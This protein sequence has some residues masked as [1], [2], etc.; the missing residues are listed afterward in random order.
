[1]LK[2]ATIN[3]PSR[4]QQSTSLQS[5]HI[6]PLGDLLDH[7]NQISQHDE[8]DSGH[9]SL[10]HQRTQS[11]LY[12]VTSQ[13]ISPARR[14]LDFGLSA[15]ICQPEVFTHGSSGQKLPMLQRNPLQCNSLTLSRQS[16][17]SD[18]HAPANSINSSQH[19]SPTS[20]ASARYP[21]MNID[22]QDSISILSS[23]A[24]L[25]STPTKATQGE[26][27]IKIF[28]QS[29]S[30]DVEYLTLQ[31]TSQT[32]SSQ[33]IRS[34]LRK[35]RLKHRDP[36]LFYLT[37]ERWIRI[38][39]IKSKN[40]MLLSDD[41]CPLQLQ[42]CCSNPPHDDIKFTLQMRA[43]A[44]VKIYCS[45]VVKD[46]R[47][48][49]LS[50]STQTT[51]EETIELMLHCLNL[52]GTSCQSTMDNMRL[53]LTGSPESTNS[54]NSSSSGVESDPNC[55]TIGNGCNIAMNTI[56]TSNHLD[57]NSRASSVTSISTSSNISSTL[58][59]SLV[60]QYC[61][62]IE[63]R[64]TNYR[65]ILES[66]EYL[67]DV[68]QNLLSE[69]KGQAVDLCQTPDSPIAIGNNN[70]S[71]SLNSSTQSTTDQWFLIK[72]LKRDDYISRQQC[73][74][75]AI[76]LNN[77]R[78]SP[79]RV[80]MMPTIPLSLINQYN[81]DTNDLK[82][83]VSTTQIEVMN[84]RSKGCSNNSSNINV[85]NSTNDGAISAKTEPADQASILP[86]KFILL[87]PVKPRRR[88]LSNASSTFGPPIMT[89][90]V[91]SH[92]RDSRRRYDPARLAEDL[93]R[94]DIAS[95]EIAE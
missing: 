38:D 46:A 29:L 34:L 93:N 37:L 72:L 51:V 86:P 6:A 82:H 63:C 26:T 7:R 62:L 18:Y 28:A 2:H 49:C 60:E 39:G 81:S 87:P 59:S 55:Q 44:L 15:P 57:S 31:V 30:Q 23:S 12:P 20:R 52:N 50:L 47:Y 75:T 78:N 69:A 54:S 11:S 5:K 91:C 21:K 45:D 10:C 66:D 67:V 85:N 32:K 71:V 1:M 40:V 14:R 48:K 53:R 22:N 74:T 56:A 24:S 88:N 89:Q 70:S 76:K 58:S 35:F 41:A 90:I 79:P 68:Y 33:I 8:V 64:D 43:G 80:P 36:N 94:L 65:R 4:A 92:G 42:Q 77:P 27:A 25:K 61:L 84:R 95:N 19:A 73:P 17:L 9:S 83:I 16:S 13:T 3:R